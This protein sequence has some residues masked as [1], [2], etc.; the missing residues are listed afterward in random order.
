MEFLDLY[1]SFIRGYAGGED[2]HL[3]RGRSSAIQLA[4]SLRIFHRLTPNSSNIDRSV[5]DFVSEHPE[6]EYTF[7]PTFKCAL[8]PDTQDY[9]GFGIKVNARTGT[10][11]AAANPSPHPLYNFTVL[12]TLVEDKNDNSSARKQAYLRFHLHNHV[13]RAWLSPHHL[14]VPRN[15]RPFLFSVHLQFDDHTI[16]RLNQQDDVVSW[17]SEP[18]D[19]VNEVGFLN[20][21][22]SAIDD[23][24]V[25]VTAV[26][27][28]EFKNSGGLDV[29]AEGVAS[30]YTL[31]QEAKLIPGSAG[32]EKRD[33]VPNFIFLA[34]GF[35][36]DDESKFN[37][38]IDHFMTSLR[39]DGKFKPF[40]RL[41]GRMNFWKVF[42]PS[43]ARG[44][45][46]KYEVFG[47]AR[48]RPIPIFTEEFEIENDSPTSEDDLNS[49]EWGPN[50]VRFYFGLPVLAHR[51]MSNAEI[52]S[53]WK[54]IS[55]LPP[56]LIDEV[57]DDLIDEWKAMA[58]RRIVEESDTFIGM[59]YGMP[60]KAKVRSDEDPNMLE[61]NSQRFERNNL[62]KFLLPLQYR[63]ENG[64]LHP[65]GAVW[66]HSYNDAV[67]ERLGKD[68]DNVVILVCSNSGRAQNESGNLCANVIDDTR[69]YIGIESD[70]SVNSGFPGSRAV[71]MTDLEAGRIPEDMPLMP[72][73]S[74]LLHEIAHSLGLGDE[75]GESRITK[76]SK[77]FQYT[78]G[79]NIENDKHY[80]NV[81]EKNDL[82]VSPLSEDIDAEKVK[83][84][85]HRI[86]RSGVLAP[87]APPAAAAI[88]R[89]GDQYTI[90]L[91]AGQAALFA[92]DDSVF[93]RR[94]KPGESILKDV[95]YDE[96]S[97]PRYP[98]VTRS[99][100]LI[101][102]HIDPAANEVVV[103]AA[104]FG[105]LTG[106]D[107]IADFPAEC[108]L[109]SPHP[110]RISASEYPPAGEFLEL[111]AANILKF[112]DNT[113]RPLHE[114]RDDL[115]NL[116]LDFDAEQSPVLV[117]IT[118][119]MC[120]KKNR[121]ITGL[122]AGGN[123]YHHGVFHSAGHC[124]MRNNHQ[125]A[126][127]CSVCKYIITD[128][129][130][131][132]L[133]PQVDV[134]FEEYYPLKEENPGPPPPF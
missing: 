19:H 89:N 50:Q 48:A 72:G 81:Q 61:I 58:D 86:A 36:R 27:S 15:I 79:G 68:Y 119:A 33:E 96:I 93:L 87:L 102:H 77:L 12:A 34:D 128:Y 40:D 63:D 57:E 108:V 46:T 37:S 91:R 14:R 4:N 32:Y 69:D 121:N 38:M 42:V 78:G 24:P 35:Q 16:R 20:F 112:M 47:E 70:D 100:E 23:A 45:A 62:N 88:T 107:L 49:G 53:Y 2:I 66:D 111:T 99:P 115:L 11:S 113:G 64:N 83:W 132:G 125:I 98:I 122:Y 126:E 94:R 21:D 25:T 71:R 56:A 55:R 127:F 22:D 92:E 73:K 97:A 41:A 104:Y 8:N 109:Y 114:K 130:D 124:I 80:S 85:W 3:M 123:R 54:Q 82:I 90:R 6:A 95:G 103:T 101:V 28:A 52:K 118:I 110:A 31:P 117:D 131:P 1:W 120:A 18:A 5:A 30:C 51:E 75:Y 39:Q 17:S 116:A 105:S 7:R 60:A 76:K 10:V 67:T 44:I 59:Y 9:E 13:A 26:L 84:R 29:H 43:V 129:V 74:T 134:L 133:H 65:L 106:H